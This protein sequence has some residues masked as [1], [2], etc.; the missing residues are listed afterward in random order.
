[1]IAEI[2][3]WV[4]GRG[5]ARS[6]GR[7]A[8]RRASTSRLAFNVSPRQ[9]DR[10]RFLRPAAPRL[11]RRRTCRCRWS[12]SNSPRPRRCNARDAVLAEIAALRADGASIAIDDFGTGYSNLARLRSMPLDRVKLDQSLIADIET[13]EKARVVVQAVVQLIKGVGCE[14][15]AEAVENS[16]ARPTSC[17]RWAATPSRAMSSPQPMTEDEFPRLDRQRR[18]Q[19]ALGRLSRRAFATIRS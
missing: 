11:R 12:S 19:R 6:L 16:R 13:G 7:L 9:L 5:R 1:M 2:G 17:A 4:I 3:D 18:P 14:V 8:A 10:R 15:V